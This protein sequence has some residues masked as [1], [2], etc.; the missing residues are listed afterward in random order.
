MKKQIVFDKYV[1]N[2]YLLTTINLLVNI[3]AKI[4]AIQTFY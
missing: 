3:L 2:Y 1:Q 4:T